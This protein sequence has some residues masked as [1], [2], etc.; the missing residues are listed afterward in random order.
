LGYAPYSADADMFA[1]VAEDL[2]VVGL[3]VGRAAGMIK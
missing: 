1:A 2:G 3:S